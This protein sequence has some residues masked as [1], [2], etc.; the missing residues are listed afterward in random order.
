CA[1]VNHVAAD[2]GEAGF[3]QARAFVYAVA[4]VEA[5]HL[6]WNALERGVGGL[7]I[8]FGAPLLLRVVETGLEKDVRQEG[9]VDL[10]QDAGRDDRL[11]FLVQLG[12]ERL[13]IVLL[14]F[15]IRVDAA[16]RRRG[17]RQEYMMIRNASGLGGGYD[18][19]DVDLKMLLA[20]VL[21][22]G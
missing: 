5:D 12:R 2:V 3:V 15:V 22:R 9:V 20:A 11:V 8:D 1:Y 4:G 18:I 17:R 7:D 10:H 19:V 13:E 14:G 21:D 16:A 6:G